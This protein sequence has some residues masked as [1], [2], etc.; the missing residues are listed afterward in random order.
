MTGRNAKTLG[1]KANAILCGLIALILCTIAHAQ[2]IDQPAEPMPPPNLAPSIQR[3]LESNLLTETQKHTARLRHGTWT[4][5]DLTT[6]AERARA[7][8]VRGNLDDP[9]LASPETNT[10][11]RAE[12]M[13]RRGELHAALEL[14][15]G[16]SSTRAIRIRA[17]TLECLGM[18][19]EA[20]AALDP[21]VARMATKPI[22]S[23]DE[24]AEGV[25]ALMVRNRLRGPG[26]AGQAG[27]DFRSLMA[28]LGRAKNDLDRLSWQARL[29]EAEILLDKDNPAEAQAALLEVLSLNPRCARAWRFLGDMAVTGFDFDR[30]ESIALRLDTLATDSP[31]AAIVRARGALRRKDTTLARDIIETALAQYPTHRELLAAQAATSAV[32]FD[33]TRTRKLLEA[34]DTL[35]GPNTNETGSPEALLAVGT[36]LA[37]ARQYADAAASLE[38]AAARQPQLA[39]PWIELGLLEMQAGRDVRARDALAKAL[40]LDPFNV[41]AKNSLALV[42]DL[43]SFAQIESEHFIVR[44]KPGLDE[45]LAAEMPAVLEAIYTD[46]CGPAMFD[47]H[48][49]TKTIIE[50]MP[51]HATFAVRITGMPQIHTMAAA[52]GPVIAMETPRSGAGHRAGP[53]DWART[54]R[55]EFIHT[56]TLSRTRNRIP[57]WFTEAAAVWGEDGP[58][59][60]NWWMLLTNAYQNETLF[61]MD[62]ISLRFVRPLTPTDRTQAYAQGH[63]MFVF[64]VERFGVRT[65]LDLMDRYATGQSEREAM[66]AVLGIT[67][68][69][70]FHDFKVWARG[71][72]V[73]AG[74]L[75]AIGQPSLKEL[76]PAGGGASREEVDVLLEA[77]PAHAELL[78]LAVR[79]ALKEADGEPNAGMIPLLERYAR[80][81]PVDPLPH[82]LLARL[83]LAGE[84]ED[85][86]E[87]AIEH[88]EFLDAREMRSPVYAL[89]LA[90]R[91]ARVGLMD[92]A[93]A[94]AKRATMIAPF[95][96]S[97]REQAARMAILRGD[98]EAAERELVALA[99]IE[100]GRELHQRRLEA[101]RQKMGG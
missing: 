18:F 3:L 50:V 2:S 9:A 83:A 19:D 73:E 55:H 39:R 17:E 26:R 53:Y 64:L 35:N 41:R 59:P 72:L 11:D 8:L 88:L 42:E 80:A 16:Q 21:L 43:A 60:S 31:D 65:P 91:Y 1:S 94:K 67:P 25:R 56:V 37:E 46:I 82:R 5:D 89:A 58:R 79:L 95:D 23:G 76:L 90:E 40:E 38:L 78:Q 99:K 97:T 12:A 33:E 71:E 34:F 66:T 10:L 51:D 100:P 44:Y 81:R 86:P 101:L 54:V 6:T 92:E 93:W 20:D 84:M 32:S 28:L 36:A 96:A 57:H 68:E 87:R 48:P 85:S 22:D 7:A 75:L 49:A 47:H 30:A 77:H 74:M 15:A 98:L 27:A 70:F 69:E 4:D 13:A 62:T 63:W 52:T 24:L 14:L 29:L 45:V 61:D